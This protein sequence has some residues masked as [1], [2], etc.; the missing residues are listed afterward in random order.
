MD[1]PPVPDYDGRRPPSCAPLP[2]PWTGA[3][4]RRRRDAPKGQ[5]RRAE[6]AAEGVLRIIPVCASVSI[7]RLLPATVDHGEVLAPFDRDLRR[8]RG[9]VQLLSLV[10]TRAAIRQTISGQN[11]PDATDGGHRMQEGFRLQ[12]SV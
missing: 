1:L 8:S 7:E 12:M 6:A 4:S 2:P 5:G 11:V 10:P 3:R 9:P